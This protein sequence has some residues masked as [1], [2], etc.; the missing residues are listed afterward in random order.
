[1]TEIIAKSK[2]WIS[3]QKHTSGLLENIA[4]IVEKCGVDKELIEHSCALHD[5]GKASPAFQIASIGNFDYAP[6]ALLPNVPHSLVSLLFILPEKIIEKHRR[7][8]FSSIAFHH[9]RDNFS[10][11]ISGVDDGFR[12]LAKR[13]LENE[14]LRKHLVQNLKTCFESDDK[15]RK[16]TEIVGFNTELAEYISEG[17]DIMHIV[18]PPYLGYF[19]PQRINLGEEE[20]NVQILNSGL[21]MRVDHFT[22]YLQEEGLIDTIEKQL[23]KYA[24]IE[25]TVKDYIKCKFPETDLSALWQIKE[26][27]DKKDDNLVVVAPTGSGKTELAALWGAGHKLFF[28]L[29]LRSAVNANFERMIKYFGQTNVGLLHSDADVYVYE[30]TGQMSDENMRTLDM[31]RLFA[32]PVQVST[33]DQ[34]FPAALKYPGYEKV[35]ATLAY[36]RLVIDEVQAYDPRSAAI[37][38]KMIEDVFTLGGKFMLMTAT[39]PDFIHAEL[40][41]RLGKE[42][43]KFIDRYIGLDNFI[44][45]EI[46]LHSTDIEDAVEDIR[47]TALEGKRVLVIANT[48][49]KAQSIF[50]TLKGTNDIKII[51]LLHSR[52]TLK[53]RADTENEMIDKEFKNPKPLEEREAKILIATQ[54]VE[55]SLDIDADVLFTEIAPMD[56]LVQRMGRVM[57]RYKA[58]DE[59]K[60]KEKGQ[61]NIFYSYKSKDKGFEIE[62]GDGYV[63]DNDLLILTLAELNGQDAEEYL[64]LKYSKDA[65]KGEKKSKKSANDI[66]QSILEHACISKPISEQNKKEMVGNVFNNLL[67]TS[68]YKKR[69]YDMLAVLDAGY[70]SDR[71]ADAARLFRE[72]FTI[73]VIVYKDEN[74][75]LKSVEEFCQSDD[76]EWVK[77][78]K[79]ILARFTIYVSKYAID[80]SSSVGTSDL[81]YDPSIDKDKLRKILRWTEDI[82]IIKDG[83]YDDKLGFTPDPKKDWRWDM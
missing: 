32:L 12:E 65:K 57:R 28:T 18:T 4:L 64:A 83:K 36:S 19:L 63:Y 1:M 44:K 35:H 2:N 70:I 50:E 74:E 20:K 48:V 81:H 59:V 15:L 10:E 49:K 72:I 23:P 33:G 39:L 80:V 56:A 73:P 75:F 31:A 41:A 71:K 22:S 62:S 47:Q 30:K 26:L 68:R 78:K 34:I 11:L 16:Y 54:V 24:D 25:Q 51:K 14:E 9:W 46:T 76:F 7:I 13:L 6:K 45:H 67:D 27:A 5:L 66:L 53:N 17:A 40:Q 69:F 8:L 3:L 55:A 61:I 29:P 38:V 82:R 37:I 58:A 52:F 60:V 21:L 79:D 77:F 42:N 43:Y